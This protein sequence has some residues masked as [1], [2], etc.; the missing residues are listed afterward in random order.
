MFCKDSKQ[1]CLYYANEYF[2]KKRALIDGLI[3][4]GLQSLNQCLLFF[5]QITKTNGKT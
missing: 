2:L 1:G 5:L 4:E 3:H